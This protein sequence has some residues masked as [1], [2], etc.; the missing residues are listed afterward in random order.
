MNLI[1]KT[2]KFLATL[3]LVLVLAVA[4]LGSFM[5]QP[6]FATSLNSDRAVS[7]QT[8]RTTNQ[9]GQQ[10]K[11]SVEK[12]QGKTQ[13]LYGNVT[14]DREAQ[15]KGKTK[16]A[17]GGIRTTQPNSNVGA[18]TIKAERDIRARQARSGQKLDR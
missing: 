12:A 14:G 1:Q 5:T 18:K 13:E 7:T 10:V 6:S 9:F 15:V 2:R 11:G 3:A 17:E 8:D 4:A 16:Q